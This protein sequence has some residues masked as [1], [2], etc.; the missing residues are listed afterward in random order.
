MTP[1]FKSFKNIDGF[2][3][4]NLVVCITNIVTKADELGCFNDEYVPDSRVM[5]G[6]K[7]NNVRPY[8]LLDKI[9]IRYC[10][11]YPFYQLKRVYECVY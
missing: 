3:L 8:F 10:E 1:R 9:C 4:G 7:C 6:S 11:Y 5:K 2:G